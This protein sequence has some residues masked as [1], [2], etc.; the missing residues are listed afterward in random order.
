VTA[1]SRTTT[2]LDAFTSII[3]NP[4]GVTE[5]FSEALLRAAS[6][7]W[8]TQPVVGDELLATIREDLGE[9]TA[10]VR[11]LSEGTLTLSGESG[12]VPVT[13][14]NDLDRS[15]TV[16]VALRSL[17]SVRLS[18]EPIEGVRIEAG[19]MASIDLDA[20]VVGSEPLPVQVQLLGPDGEDYGRPATI[21]LVSTAYAQAAAW[22]VAA[23]FLAIVIFVVVGVARRIR[24]ARAAARPGSR[25]A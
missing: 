24:K 22:V 5:P 10:R 11:V 16:G 17:P 3:D 1:I 4:V 25:P 18:S 12:R 2:Q 19:R 6:S 9:Q 20:R 21:T 23:A 15:V 14:A 8:R 7:G 13:I